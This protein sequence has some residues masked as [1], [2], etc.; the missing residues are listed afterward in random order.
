MKLVKTCLGESEIGVL[1]SI[2]VYGNRKQVI[3]NVDQCLVFRDQNNT[4]IRMLLALEEKGSYRFLVVEDIG[5]IERLCK[6]A[7][8][9]K[10][11]S[12][13]PAFSDL[14]A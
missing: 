7:K 9:F 13:H 6:G 11:E 5:K 12:I 2:P 10:G 1:S 3:A 14:I 8:K 4:I